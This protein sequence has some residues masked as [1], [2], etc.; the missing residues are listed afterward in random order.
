[1]STAKRLVTSVTAIL[2]LVSTLCAQQQTTTSSSRSAITVTAASSAERVRFTAPST[3][4]QMRIEV[5]ATNGEK[6]FDN[7]IR[8]GNVIDWYLQ[9]GQAGRLSDGSYLCVITSKSLSGR[10][11]QRLG[12][13]TIENT[14]PSVQTT[15]T[16]Q[17]TNQQTQAV[18]P[19]EE[20]ASL[21]VLKDGENQTATVIAH[22]G[23]EGQIIRGRGALSFRIGDFF[24]GKDTEQMRLTADGNFG[25][26]LAHPQARLDV[27]GLIR[28]SKGIVFPDGTIQTT[29]AN[30]ASGAQASDPNLVGGNLPGS[31]S[32]STSSLKAGKGKVKNK[33]SPELFVNEDLTVNGNIIFTP[34]IARDITVQNNNGGI[35]IFADT[36]LSGSPTTAAIQF[37]GNGYPGFP[38]QA[39][40][41]SGAHDN[42]A[43]IFR[44][45][46]TGG[47]I[48]ERMRIMAAG[49]VGIGTN[50]PSA[51]LNVVGSQPPGS[52]PVGIDASPA[53]R[54]I[55]GKGGNG[56]S[57]ASGGLVLIQAGDGGNGLSPSFSPGNGG[58]ITL[59]PGSR[60]GG[61]FSG[62]AG[63]LLLAPGVGNVGI[64]TTNPASKLVVIDS[65]NTGLRVQ[66]NTAG[67]TL[68][69]FGGFGDFQI[70]ANGTSGGRLMVKENG[71]VG[72]G[73]ASPLYKL[74]VSAGSDQN[75]V[76]GPIPDGFGG[77][78]PG[79]GIQAFNDAGT[80]YNPLLL[81]G[82]NVTI[83]GGVGGDG[84]NVAIGSSGGSAVLT[85]S[86]TAKVG[87]GTTDP[88]AKL[89]VAGGHLYIANQNHLIITSPDGSCWHL[90]VSNTGT[91]STIALPCP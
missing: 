56:Q 37:F 49:N 90:L 86:G 64:G 67:G 61:G 35:R 24:S 76:F 44:T 80:A 8:G 41:D 36:A 81:E 43:V 3:V 19:L 58:S 4:V 57:G 65:S 12:K 71:K 23:E 14:V 30:G 84:G 74:H 53:L 33:V 50:A 42:A 45:A 22:N 47:T 13:V 5:Y 40:I 79:I 16:T 6:L 20:N 78:I 18:G 82:S 60:G 10:M 46:V 27:D 77:F 69:S 75:L 55:G 51:V 39:Y 28:T 73:T 59:Q 38:G 48:T 54:V 26:G 63:N 88:H 68:A 91:L 21:T 31:T 17:L 66:T 87:I 29:A 1:M 25:I 70:D 32:L 83:N 11:S 7:E 85:V 2:L 52:P 62:V 34:S 15:D 89:H 72:I 9:D